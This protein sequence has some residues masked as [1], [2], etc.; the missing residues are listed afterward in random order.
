MKNLL[1]T[2]IVAGVLTLGALGTVGVATAAV[3]TPNNVTTTINGLKADGFD[4][5]VNRVGTAPLAAC[6][7]DAVRPGHQVTRTDSGFP[8]DSL[9]TTVVSKTVYVDLTC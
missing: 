2:T 3:P 4:V 9:T 7:V 1:N 5:I 6:S 8:G